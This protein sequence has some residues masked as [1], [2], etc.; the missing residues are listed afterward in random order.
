MF[1]S[2][3]TRQKVFVFGIAGERAYYVRLEGSACNLFIVTTHM[4]HRDRDSPDQ[5]DTIKDLHV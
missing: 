4:S 1:L 5:D 3:T 2:K